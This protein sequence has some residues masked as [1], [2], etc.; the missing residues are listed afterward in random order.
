VAQSIDEFR[1]TTH[2]EKMLPRRGLRR[3]VVA[4]VLAS[5]G[6]RWTVRAGRDVLQSRIQLE[7]RLYLVR[8][9]VDVG[10]DPPAVVTAYRTSKVEKYWSGK[11]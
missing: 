10:T 11:P 4:K 8:V 5:P 6:Q 1:L 7:G 3:S 2:A 9:F